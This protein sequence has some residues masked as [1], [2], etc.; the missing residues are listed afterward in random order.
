EEAARV[1]PPGAVPAQERLAE[2]GSSPIVNLSVIYDRPITDLPM[3][4]AVS[5]PVQWVFDRT[6]A[7]GLEQGQCL[8][9][10]LSAAEQWLGYPQ[11]QPG[12]VLPA[13]LARLLPAAGAARVLRTVVSRERAATFR[14]VPGTAK[15]RPPARTA[16]PG[17]AVAGAWTD[18]GWPA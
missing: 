12:S 7:A 10:S 13:E 3:A 15:L 1:L 17:V 14:A 9:V 4:A 5:S 11:A 6:E 2:P 18:T 16:A 8:T